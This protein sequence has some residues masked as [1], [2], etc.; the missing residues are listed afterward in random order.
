M[1]ASVSGAAARI[2]CSFVVITAAVGLSA[3]GSEEE[4][5]A[6]CTVVTT[7][8]V[9]EWTQEFTPDTDC[10]CA[11]ERLTCHSLWQTRIA[12]V[13]GGTVTLETHKMGSQTGPSVDVH[14]WVVDAPAV[15]DCLS[16][17]DAPA[18]VEGT[19]TQGEAPLAVP[20]ELWPDTDTL[21]DHE[22]ETYRLGMITGGAEHEEERIWWT[23]DSVAVTVECE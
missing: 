19:W 21:A 14:Y 13:D 9:G 23:F 7:P 11:E 3:C 8:A 4:N 6:V 15:P 16:M 2:V 5:V 20:V 22:G 12:S 1:V 10:M 18:L 17:N